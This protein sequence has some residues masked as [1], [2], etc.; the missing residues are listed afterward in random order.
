MATS[1]RPLMYASNS[2]FCSSLMLSVQSLRSSLLRSLPCERHSSNILFVST[3]LISVLWLL[4]DFLNAALRLPKR[5]LVAIQCV[6]VYY[7]VCAVSKFA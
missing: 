3:V 4:S 7:H 5:L 1:N 2:I 6:V